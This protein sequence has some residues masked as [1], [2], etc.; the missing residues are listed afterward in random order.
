MYLVEL[1]FYQTSNIYYV[2]KAFFFIESGVV[3][4]I[5]E[6]LNV[7]R[8]LDCVNTPVEVTHTIFLVLWNTGFSMMTEMN[9]YLLFSLLNLVLC[10]AFNNNFL[11]KKNY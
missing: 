2:I 11:S 5:L 1:N 6:Y 9:Y 8:L 3:T 10:S 4:T 7:S